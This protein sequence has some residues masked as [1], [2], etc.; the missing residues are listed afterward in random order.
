M[1]SYW[2]NLF[3][4][5]LLDD[6]S[7][8]AARRAAPPLSAAEA[9]GRA[10]TLQ[11]P[12]RLA[13]QRMIAAREATSAEIANHALSRPSDPAA[14]AEWEAAGEQLQSQLGMIDDQLRRSYAD[15]ARMDPVAA[16]AI[17][18]D[19]ESIAAAFGHRIPTR[20]GNTLPD[21]IRAARARIAENASAIPLTQ[22][23]AREAKE[24]EDAIRG[25][26][27][28][29][30]ATQPQFGSF[31][32]SPFEIAQNPV[33][34][35]LL[36]GP[37][38]QSML[39]SLA[40][41]LG[42]S[43]DNLELEVLEAIRKGALRDAAEGSARAGAISGPQEVKRSGDASPRTYLQ[44]TQ[45]ILEDLVPV[46]ADLPL[47]PTRQLAIDQATGRPALDGDDNPTIPLVPDD[48]LPARG[49]A[50]WMQMMAGNYRPL[51]MDYTQQRGV[52]AGRMVN[53]Q[54]EPDFD[55]PLIPLVKRRTG[56]DGNR[57]PES[58]VYL[59]P[60]KD[61]RVQV[62]ASDPVTGAQQPASIIDAPGIDRLL[63]DGYEP[64]AALKAAYRSSLSGQD[65]E[66]VGRRVFE[67]SSSVD[68]TTGEPNA[69]LEAIRS[70]LD[71]VRKWRMVGNQSDLDVLHDAA[72]LGIPGSGQQRIATL[73][74]MLADAEARAVN[75]PTAPDEMAEAEAALAAAANVRA[76]RDAAVQ[77]GIATAD[78]PEMAMLADPSITPSVRVNR[79]GNNVLGGP[80]SDSGRLVPQLRFSPETTGGSQILAGLIPG[81]EVSDVGARLPAKG[82]GARTRAARAAQF[83]QDVSAGDGSLSIDAVPPRHTSVFDPSRVAPGTV[84]DD[85]VIPGA[86][87]DAASR[88]IE[89]NPALSPLDELLGGRA[90]L[91]PVS[92]IDFMVPPNSWAASALSSPGE[93]VAARLAREAQL[94]DPF[95]PI[96]DVVGAGPAGAG[97]SVNFAEAGTPSAGVGSV[98]VSADA[99][100]IARRMKTSALEERLRY[101]VSRRSQVDRSTPSGQAA[102]DDLTRSIDGV[103]GELRDRINA[104]GDVRDQR[105]L[106]RQRERA[107]LNAGED[108]PADFNPKLA[109]SADRQAEEFADTADVLRQSSDEPADARRIPMSTLRSLW[110][111]WDGHP[112][113]DS[114]SVKPQRP[115]AFGNLDSRPEG[116]GP[117]KASVERYAERLQD[118]E[119]RA[120][121]TRQEIDSVKAQRKSASDPFERSQLDGKLK[122]LNGALRKIERER[123]RVGSSRLGDSQVAKDS[124]GSNQGR[125]IGVLLA[126]DPARPNSGKLSD[127]DRLN[128][129]R[130][131]FSTDYSDPARTLEGIRESAR[132]RGLP[133][134]SDQQIIYSALANHPSARKR[135]NQDLLWDE[136]GRAA[137]T[138]NRLS[139][140][141][142]AAPDA[143]P[144]PVA[145]SQPSDKPGVLRRLLGMLV[146]DDAQSAASRAASSADSPLD[147][148]HREIPTAREITSVTG[149]TYTPKLD[150]GASAEAAGRLRDMESRLE[151]IDKSIDDSLGPYDQA[152]DRRAWLEQQKTMRS[153][154]EER[155]E[156][157]RQYQP[158]LDE[159]RRSVAQGA[160]GRLASVEGRIP[161]FRPT[162]AG[163]PVDGSYADS[164]RAAVAEARSALRSILAPSG[165]SVAPKFR[166]DAERVRADL[167]EKMRKNDPARRRPDTDPLPEDPEDM[168][169]LMDSYERAGQD[170]PYSSD[171]AETARAMQ[172]EPAAQSESRAAPP[173]DNGAILTSVRKPE[174]IYAEMRSLM[175]EQGRIRGSRS[176]TIGRVDTNYDTSKQSKEIAARLRDL[177]AELEAGGNEF[178]EGELRSARPQPGEAPTPTRTPLDTTRR[179]VVLN[180]DVARAL[181]ADYAGARNSGRTSFAAHE[182]QDGAVQVSMFSNGKLVGVYQGRSALP[183]EYFPELE[184]SSNKYLRISGEGNVT[185]SDGPFARSADARF[186]E[187]ADDAAILDSAGGLGRSTPR[188]SL[189][190]KGSGARVP[191][192][193]DW[194]RS[195]PAADDVSEPAVGS[196]KPQPQSV[197]DA[198]S[199]SPETGVARPLDTS[200]VDLSE[201]AG[202]PAVR[203][204]AE[205]AA[206]RV[207]QDAVQ[208]QA[209]PE[210]TTPPAQ[211]SRL[212]RLAKGGAAGIGL[213]YVGGHVLDD[214]GLLP[215]PRNIAGAIGPM[216]VGG[217]L[218]APVGASGGGESDA[219]EDTNPEEIVARVRQARTPYFIAGHILP[220]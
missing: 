211:R 185:V 21:M 70:A 191:G 171:Q 106:E 71:D 177:K 100:R 136:A 134:P 116:G 12:T 84:V 24:L 198:T 113:T 212:G 107:A 204:G 132:A 124:S 194:N 6:A 61:G 81:A 181:G 66:A 119:S 182:M 122:Q 72:G 83:S 77:H 26:A 201:V 163:W 189:D 183:G 216:L 89:T 197:G 75:V 50:S 156:L 37:R 125:L 5:R 92:T 109:E 47:R 133:E 135:Y 23:V 159:F 200:R 120:S 173:V 129:L 155:I 137:E 192:T 142:S 172:Q 15:V 96:S 203:A 153:N 3:T 39:S 186:A 164:V 206:R 34:R 35:Q 199:P 53:G 101:L 213:A 18:A 48:R 73:E 150:G 16:Q 97:R 178:S 55:K 138:I 78:R 209:A 220:R 67:V 30:M 17:G 93:P 126:D 180:E 149:S 196:P 103:Y 154:N 190:D 118:I 91:S 32:I 46:E 127:A 10:V 7:S 44:D 158:A 80:D 114:G 90:A 105:R 195:P 95:R 161:S 188:T 13:L 193:R 179:D 166:S 51:G 58:I 38:G 115:L 85:S 111:S 151:A 36:D 45:P 102:Y 144:P 141:T 1:A 14:V 165:V 79:A 175:D 148:L 145:A 174:E 43:G 8:A 98:D 60:R 29:R 170:L 117:S 82:G 104:R 152:P 131:L 59:L 68:P 87:V 28:V 57:S 94:S 219:P 123:D 76:A 19:T 31:E 140:S 110:S 112:R 157:M 205:P 215:D 42:V 88:G 65:P 62:I 41:K 108:V 160:E 9:V 40:A 22:G 217:M 214:A 218:A 25:A 69:T 64:P 121:A 146:P 63:A 176:T 27:T 210:P 208:R 49:S 2:D 207:D 139:P 56:G 162:T 11:P 54:V 143:P 168:A 187:D 86:A 20:V 128:A 130:E 99:V 184:G 52:F 147:S 33:V 4:G 167:M 169:D 74:Q 202:D